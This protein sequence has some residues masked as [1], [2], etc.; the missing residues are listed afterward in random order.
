MAWSMRRLPGFLGFCSAASIRRLGK[1][2]SLCF[3]FGVQSCSQWVT[4]HVF[5]RTLIYG[6]SF[7][8]G[9]GLCSNFRLL[10]RLHAITGYTQTKLRLAR[11]WISSWCLRAPCA[12][13]QFQGRLSSLGPLVLQFWEPCPRKLSACAE[14]ASAYSAVLMHSVSSGCALLEQSP[15]HC[16]TPGARVCPV[17]LFSR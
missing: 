11:S 16:S 15:A 14:R 7:G 9:K 5:F 6:R 1:A 4:S 17:Q 2:S 12:T 13:V 8:R 10:S 3:L